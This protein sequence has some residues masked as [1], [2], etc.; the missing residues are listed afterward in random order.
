MTI[1]HK[2]INRRDFL[3]AIGAFTLLSAA[4]SPAVAKPNKQPIQSATLTETSVPTTAS[5]TPEP[6]K[7]TA[8]LEPTKAPP[9]PTAEPTKAATPEAKKDEPCN[10]LPQEYCSQGK[11]IYTKNSSGQSEIYIGFHLLPNIPIFAGMSGQTGKAS[12]AQPSEF[13][14]YQLVVRDPNLSNPNAI[15]FEI[16]GDLQFDNMLSTNVNE[17]DIIGYTQNTGVKNLGD[18]NV[19][20]TARRRTPNGPVPAKDILEKLF[21]SAFT[22]P[23]QIRSYEGPSNPASTVLSPVFAPTK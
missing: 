20:I 15:S 4:C 9:T 11:L 13:T 23:A 5:P 17:G 8:T 12:I 3:K 14:G 10:I 6:T 1:E 19:L 22:N 2:K 21:Q 7:P 16:K 18:Y